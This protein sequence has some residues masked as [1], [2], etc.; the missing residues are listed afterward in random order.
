VEIPQR[1]TTTTPTSE[2]RA[3]LASPCDDKH[4]YTMWNYSDHDD[5]NFDYKGERCSESKRKKLFESKLMS[6]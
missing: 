1:T 3:G 5:N 4:H 6:S 2:D